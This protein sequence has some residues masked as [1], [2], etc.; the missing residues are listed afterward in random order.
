M[1]VGLLG[2]TLVAVA[3]LGAGD[4]AAQ[5]EFEPVISG[6]ASP[7][8]VTAP[9]G[10]DRLFVL[11]QDGSIR[12]V[13]NGAILPT[14]FLDLTGLTNQVGERGLLGMAFHPDYDSNGLFYVHYSRASDG[15]TI[16]AEYEVSGDPNV[17]D[18]GSAAILLTEA[19]PFSNHNGGMLAFKPGEPGNYLYMAIGDGGDAGDPMGN[20]QNTD[21]IL[22]AVLRLDVDNGGMAPAS[23]PFVGVDGDDRIWQYGLRNPW[24]FSFDS[25]TG[26]MYIGDVGQNNFEEINF[27]PAN[28]TGGENLGWDLL[29]GSNDFECVDCDQA[30]MNTLLPIHEYPHTDGIS[31]TGGYVYRGSEIPSLQ[32]TYFFGDYAGRIWS[33]RYDGATMTEFQEWDLPIGGSE[34]VVSFGEDGFGELYFVLYSGTIYKLVDNTPIQVVS[35]TGGGLYEEGETVTLSVEVTGTVGD[36]TYEWF[37]NNSGTPLSDGGNISGAAT[38]DVTFSPAT[39]ADSGSYVLEVTDEAK[40]LFVVPPIALQVVAMGSLPAMGMLGLGLGVGI[41]MAVGVWRL[42]TRVNRRGR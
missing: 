16:L 23:N 8:F 25:G 6:F 33:F 42:R 34:L 38:P 31:V 29:E 20:G 3:L 13:E 37:K 41:L 40:A 9:A 36:V 15:A 11:E 35:R 30:R 22:G 28:S 32:G 1:R 2:Y 18:A 21:T 26:D 14:P 5:I 24:R 19:Q 10:D 27:I 17:A 39:I 7:I 4:A 12:I